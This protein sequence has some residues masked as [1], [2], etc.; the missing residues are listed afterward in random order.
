MEIVFPKL[1]QWQQDVYDAVKDSYGTGKIFVTKSRRQLGKS[2]LCNIILI[3]FSLQ[4][5]GSKNY[6]IE[7]TIINVEINIWNLKNG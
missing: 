1:K 5:N 3:T 4:H 7:P 6:M 2:T